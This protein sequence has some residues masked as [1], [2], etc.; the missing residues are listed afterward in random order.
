MRRMD[1]SVGAAH[2]VLY[3]APGCHLC[4]DTRAVIE[5]LL[6]ERR[7]AGRSGVFIE[8]VDITADQALHLTFMETIPVVEVGDSRLELATSPARVRAFLARELDG[9]EAGAS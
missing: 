9:I 3:G 1:P 2:I 8:D 4:H 7:A 5:H 6:A